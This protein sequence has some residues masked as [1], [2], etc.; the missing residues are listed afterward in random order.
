MFRYNGTTVPF[1]RLQGD[2][3]PGDEG[4][5]LGG[6]TGPDWFMGRTTCAQQGKLPESGMKLPGGSCS[7]EA[8]IVQSRRI[9][10]SCGRRGNAEKEAE[11]P[12]GTD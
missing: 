5:V 2:L 4:R 7:G 10:Q 1:Y 8:R 9:I 12:I 3:R 6:M 11:S